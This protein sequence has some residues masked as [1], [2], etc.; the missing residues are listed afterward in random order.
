MAKKKS[1][2]QLAVEKRAKAKLQAEINKMISQKGM[3]STIRQLTRRA[4]RRIERA[5]GGQR[6]YLESLVK[7]GKFSAAT[8]GLTATQQRAMI[9]KLERFLGAMSTTKVGWDWIRMD[10]VHRT[11]ETLSGYE[12]EK[13]RG[14][15]LTDEELA[16]ILIQINDADKTEFYRVINL[17]E[18]ARQSD[19]WKGTAEQIAEVIRQKIDDQT[20]FA[21]A[22]EVRKK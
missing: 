6:R 16:E 4:N 15:T 8:K 9:N 12:N 1:A 19:T 14:Y 5:T 3:S 21:M 22:K 2:D 7:G 18:V 11:A 13:Y 20:A 10:I 17:V